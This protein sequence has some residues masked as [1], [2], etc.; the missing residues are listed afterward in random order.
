MI[1]PKPPAWFTELGKTY[2]TIQILNINIKYAEAA[3]EVTEM[4]HLMASTKSSR[5]EAKKQERRELLWC[6][7][8][9]CM[10][11]DARGQWKEHPASRLCIFLYAAS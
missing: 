7:V 6:A 8:R 5:G 1:Q 11:D 4:R 2:Y 3:G 9:G 10:P